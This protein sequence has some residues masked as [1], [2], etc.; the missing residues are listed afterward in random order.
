MN[1][2]QNKKQMQLVDFNEKWR[3]QRSA[4]MKEVDLLKCELPTAF[5]FVNF[6]TTEGRLLYNNKEKGG[7]YQ[8]K[9]QQQRYQRDLL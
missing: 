5:I 8:Q 6:S 7:R 4:K 3:Y 2:E 1:R 9:Q